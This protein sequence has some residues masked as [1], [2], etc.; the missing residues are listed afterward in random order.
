ML[1]AYLVRWEVI[2]DLQ[3]LVVVRSRL[4]FSG[5]YALMEGEAL[6]NH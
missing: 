1:R 5:L 3:S 4:D 6:G 2:P